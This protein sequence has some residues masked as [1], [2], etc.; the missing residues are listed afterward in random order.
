MTALRYDD[1]VLKLRYGK[2]FQEI[3]VAY[4]WCQS[5]DRFVGEIIAFE[6]FDHG[7]S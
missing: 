2:S 1:L 4:S 7:L 3:W 6:T 5:S